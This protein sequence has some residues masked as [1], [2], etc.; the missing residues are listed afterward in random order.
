[1]N[2]EILKKVY[3]LAKD[4]RQEEEKNENQESP[5]IDLE[6]MRIKRE[7]SELLNYLKSLTFEENMM[8]LTV[9]YIG[10]DVSIDEL[11]EY[12]NPEDLFAKHLSIYKGSF[13]KKEYVINQ[14]YQKFPLNEYLANGFKILN[15]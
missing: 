9:M 1:M 15:I 10:R 11:N 4:R 12:E 13:E 14:I 8:V 5:Q 6:E 3:E 2:I 7:K